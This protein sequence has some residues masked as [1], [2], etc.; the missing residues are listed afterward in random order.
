MFAFSMFG[1]GSKVLLSVNSAVTLFRPRLHDTV[2]TLYWIAIGM[3]ISFNWI[4]FSY[5]VGLGLCVHDTVLGPVYM[6]SDPL[7]FMN[8]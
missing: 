3:K 4:Q 6:G 5:H 2:F 8:S 1:H 7:D